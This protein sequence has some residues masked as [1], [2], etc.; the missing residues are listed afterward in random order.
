MIVE[1]KAKQYYTFIASMWSGSL[2]WNELSEDT[3]NMYRERI[4]AIENFNIGHR[5]GDL[6]QRKSL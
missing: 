5:D 2:S 6:Q 3:K 1:E 4:K